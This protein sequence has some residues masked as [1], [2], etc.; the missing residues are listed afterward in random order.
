MHLGRLLLQKEAKLL[1]NGHLVDQAVI[2]EDEDEGL[3]RGSD[4]VDQAR[5]ERLWRGWLGGL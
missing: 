5:E 4:V 2:V 1:V 3:G